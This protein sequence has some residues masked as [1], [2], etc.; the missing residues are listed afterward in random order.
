VLAKENRIHGRKAFL[1]I[2]KTNT[3]IRGKYFNL[4]YSPNQTE[5]I[6]AA[7]VVGKK[8]SK[9]A[10]DRNRLRR[11]IF[12]IL[13]KKFALALSGKNIIIIVFNPNTVNLKSSEIE[14]LIEQ[15]V[16]KIKT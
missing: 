10:V 15:L 16:A 13:R 12:E 1:G 6:K 8:I 5:K 2:L 7:V 3:V 4:S 14:E 9:K 11:K